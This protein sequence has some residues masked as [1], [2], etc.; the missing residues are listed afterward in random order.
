ML[1]FAEASINNSFPHTKRLLIYRLGKCEIE[2]L[3]R[4]L[5]SGIKARLGLETPKTSSTHPKTVPI[6]SRKA[7]FVN[8][9]RLS[10][11]H[12]Y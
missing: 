4:T 8:A 10:Q 7:P 1:M 11:L 2:K 6:V 3:L 9:S 5:H 12:N